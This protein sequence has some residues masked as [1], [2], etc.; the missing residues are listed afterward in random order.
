MPVVEER[1]SV[2]EVQ[3]QEVGATLARIEDISGSLVKMVTRLDE[4]VEGWISESKGSTCEARLSDQKL[5]RSG[6][7]I[8]PSSTPLGLFG[9]PPQQIPLW[10]IGIQMTTLIAIVAGLFG[11]VAN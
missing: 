6:R 1:L 11:I 7:E 10:L 9:E 3:M 5:D 4:R 8:H 2:L